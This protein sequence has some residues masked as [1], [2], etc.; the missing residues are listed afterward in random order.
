MKDC[1]PRFSAQCPVPKKA[2]CCYERSDSTRGA[3]E[4]QKCAKPGVMLK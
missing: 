4:P 3:Q 2:W 1:I